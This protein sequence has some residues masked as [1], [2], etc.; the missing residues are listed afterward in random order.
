[1]KVR[2]TRSLASS[3]PGTSRIGAEVEVPDGLAKGWIEMGYATA[4]QQD[5]PHPA[6]K[7]SKKVTTPKE[8]K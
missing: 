2:M 4:A 8:T 6:K 7:R 1:M 3:Y 5:A